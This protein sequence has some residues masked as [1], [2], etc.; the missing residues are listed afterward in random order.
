M[1]ARSRRIIARPLG[2]PSR[3]RSKKA[4]NPGGPIEAPSV[5]PAG[6]P[7]RSATRPP[8]LAP[9]GLAAVGRGPRRVRDLRLGAQGRDAEPRAGRRW[10]SRNL[11]KMLHRAGNVDGEGDGCGLLVDI[12]RKDLGRGGARRRPQ[13]GARARRRRSRSP[14]SSSSAPQDLE[15]GPAR[16]PRDPRRAAASGSSPSASARSTRRR[17]APTAREEEPHFWQVGGL[18]RRRRAA[19]TASSSTSLIELEQRARLP[20]RLVLG[21]RPASTR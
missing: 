1:R 14:T 20:R 11:Q 16:R 17:S 18:R 3:A 10:R 5:P 19:A 13:P 6:L 8:A 7:A 4:R 2:S 12:P 21:R 9:A 15:R